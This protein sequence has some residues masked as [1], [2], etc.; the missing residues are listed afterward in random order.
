MNTFFRFKSLRTRLAFWFLLVTMLCLLAVVT[1]LYFQRSEDIHNREFEK[2]EIGRDLKV[3]ELNAWLEE[4][5]SDLQVAAWDDEI[6]GLEKVVNKTKDDWTAEDLKTVSVAKTLMQRY[7]GAYSA[8]HEVFFIEATSGRV[9]ISTEPTRE[10]DDKSEDPYF[11]ETK[12]TRKPFIKDIYDSKTEGEPAMAFAAPI[13]CLEHDGEQLIGVLVMR[14]NLE[15]DL[16]PLLQ[17]R[18]GAGETG[19]TFIVNK[20]GFAVNALRWHDS[21][22]LKLQITAVPAVRAVGGETGI[23]E[24]KDYRGEMVLAAYTH[25]PLMGWG[26]VAKRDLAEIYAPINTMLRDMVVLVLVSLLVVLFV[27]FL[28]SGTIASPVAGIGAIVRRFSEGDLDARCETEGVDEVATLG[29]LF[30]RMAATLA[31]EMTIQRHTSEVADT[32]VGAGNMEKFASGL[33]M[34]LIEISDSHLGAFYLRSENGKRLEHFTSVGLSDDAAQSFSAEDREGELGQALATG[35]ISCLRDISPDTAFTFKTTGGTA[36]PREIMTIPLIIERRVMAVVS[37]ATLSAYSDIQRKIIVQTHIGMNT[38][39]SN[40]MA[41]MKTRAL[42]DELSRKNT[43]LTAQASEMQAQSQELEAQRDELQVQTT[44]LEARRIQVEA[45]DRLKSEFLS[46]M[47]HELRTP[48]N[49]IMSLSQLM[50]SRGVDKDPAKA[51]GYL[52]VID[53]NGRQLLNLIND[54][55]DLTKIESGRMDIFP[56]K[57]EAKR[58]INRVLETV[59]PIA[60]KKNIRFETSIDQIPLLF[61][62]EDKVYQILLNFCSNAIKFTEKGIVNIAVNATGGKVSFMV[63]DTGIG[64]SADDLATIFNEFRQVD[65]SFTR[66][67]EGTGLGLAISRKLA[68]LLGGNITV[69]SA[70]GAGST[71]TFTL[72]TSVSGD[73]IPLETSAALPRPTAVSFQH[74]V[75]HTV[76]V[77]DDEEEAR[78]TLSTYLTEGGYKVLLA[79]SGKEGLEMAKALQPDV[80]SLDLLMPDMDG[81]E[82][83]RHLKSAPETVAIPIIITSVSKDKETGWALGAAGYVPKPVNNKLLLEEIRRVSGKKPAKRLL[84]ADDDSGVQEF[85]KNFLGTKGFIVETAGNGKEALAMVA[86]SPPHLLILDLLMPDVDGFSVLEQLRENPKTLDLPVIILT[87]KDLTKEDLQRLTS[88][89]KTISKD[90]LNKE[91]F[92]H[93]IEGALAGQ[94]ERSTTELPLS[95]HI[96]VVEDNEIASEQIVAALQE[97]G[98]EVAVAK[99]GVEGL[100]HVKR[101]IPAGIILDLMMPRVDGFQVLEQIRSRPET[102]RIPVLILTA[103]E[104][105]ASERAHLTNNN[106]QQLIQKGTADRDQL[107]ASVKRLVGAS[108]TQLKKPAPKTVRSGAGTILMVEDNADNRL[109]ITAIIEEEG[110]E[111]IIAENGE[112]GVQMAGEKMPDLILM[113]IQLPVMSGIDAIKIIKKNPATR[114]IP[115]IAVTARAMKGDRKNILAEGADDYISKPIN[116][117]ELQEKV[118][119]WMV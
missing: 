33:L 17:D 70:P 19:E 90:K 64:I 93:Q 14:A 88:A 22:P 66:A 107:V 16:Y 48:L 13:F 110:C 45:A 28:L 73:E 42:A 92:L 29:T 10:G 98:F 47:S 75:A 26:L 84:I 6:R 37:L 43:E 81:L 118:R 103:K 24:S 102:A 76:L 50:I 59:T 8:Y 4:R 91:A 105:S 49:S 116:P 35:R 25:I 104:I 68:L 97:N 79:R 39:L 40:L 109:T 114:A 21:A 52:K 111:I 117:A 78:S 34:K 113:D 32:M 83:L 30:N 87:S 1:I 58:I 108:R 3:R 89:V 9:L 12:R 44:E 85:L 71:F 61:S 96:L 57:F 106:I 69:E 72:P 77:I 60:Q 63:K 99:D 2:L 115:I 15:N 53:R 67:Q 62:D 36:V 20:D 55:L 23:V 74:D 101:S 51:V 86:K 65:G 112:Q 119:K 80:I 46:N 94:Q 27:S 38:A 7:L 95:N 41:N 54:I 18:I 5:M 100:A 31:S 56:T 11:I 82:V